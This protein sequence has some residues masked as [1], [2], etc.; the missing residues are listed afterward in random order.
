MIPKDTQLFPSPDNRYVSDK[1]IQNIS[2]PSFAVQRTEVLNK[3][4][5]SRCLSHFGRGPRHHKEK[6]NH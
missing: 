6:A 5:I 3:Q 2:E 1:T 4:L